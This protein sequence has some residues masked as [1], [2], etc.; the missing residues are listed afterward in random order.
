MKHLFEYLLSLRQLNYEPTRH[1]K[2][3]EKAW[4][5]DELE[6]SEGFYLGGTGL[7]S[8]AVL[9]VH[10]QQFNE[11]HPAVDQ[12]LG[13]LFQLLDFSFWK[14]NQKALTIEE[15]HVL[16]R[17]K[18]M[19]LNEKCTDSHE[20]V[21]LDVWDQFLLG[22][23]L[24]SI[25]VK[26][27]NKQ[28]IEVSP[29]V[30]QVLM[31]YETWLEQFDRFVDVRKRK[32]QI[33]RF[34]DYLFQLK[35]A[36][37]TED[38][39]IEIVLGTG[40]LKYFAKHDIY[41]PLFLTKLDLEF[42]A[43]KGLAKLVPSTKGS[44]LELEMLTGLEL[45]NHDQIITMYQETKGQFINPFKKAE[46]IGLLSE[47][48]HYLHPNGI[49]KL[50]DEP[51][52]QPKDPIVIDR[53]MIFVRKKSD[54]LL[55]E[56]LKKTLDYL[57]DGGKISKTIQAIVD[58]EALQLDE[59]EIKEWE[60]I[61]DQLLFPLPANDEQK[62]IVRRLAQ[63]IAI[64]VQGPP[65]TGKSHT[66]VN[67]I[68]H[69][70]A[71]GKKVLI[72]SEKD[73]ALRVLMDKMPE[74]IAPFCVSFLGGSKDVLAQIESSIT[75]L[76]D[77]LANYDEVILEKD[78]KVLSRQ[79]DMIHRQMNLTK[80]N[81]V[82]FKELDAKGQVFKD[83][84]IQPIEMAKL[85][86]QKSE[87]FSWFKDKVEMDTEAPLTEDE[88]VTLWELKCQLPK[89][90]ADIVQT[91][92]P[93]MQKLL[94]PEEYKTLLDS[95]L[96]FMTRLETL[97]QFEGL[98]EFPKDEAYIDDVY[99]MLEILVQKLQKIQ[100]DYGNEILKQCLLNKERYEVFKRIYDKQ[101]DVLFGI[102]ER[103]LLLVN[104]HIVC[105]YLN[106][107]KFSQYVDL[108][109][110]KVH[111][112]K[113]FTPLL[114]K[115]HKELRQFYETTYING[116]LLTD[117]DDFKRLM[118]Y[119][120]KMDLL[121]QFKVLWNK[122][123]MQCGADEIEDMAVHHVFEYNQKVKYF[124]MVLECCHLISS[125]NVKISQQIPSYIGIEYETL[126][127]LD[128]L[129]KSIDVVR[130]KL[131]LAHWEQE[132]EAFLF[133]MKAMLCCE[134]MHEMSFALYDSFVEKDLDG[135]TSQLGQIQYLTKIKE[136][137]T[138]FYSHLHALKT[139]MPMF[140]NRILNQL[141]LQEYLPGS[142]QDILEYGKLMTFL[143]ALDEWDVVLLE[144]KLGLLE[145]ESLKV[146]KQ[147]IYK[148]TWKNQLQ[149]V[150]PEQDRALSVWMQK[151]ARI[152]KGTGKLSDKYRREAREEME[153][154]QSAIPVWIM[155]I[156]EAIENFKVNPDLFD[157]VIM[158][159]SSQSN[160]L[161]LPIFMRAKR[162][163]IVGD[164]QQI[165]PLTPGVSDAQIQ[166][167]LTRHLASIDNGNLYDLQTSL[168]DIANH[169]FSSKGK[170]M[171]KEHFRCVPEIIEFSNDLCY[172]HEMIPLK[173]P[174]QFEQLTPPVMAVYVENGSRDDRRVNLEEAKQ[175]VADIKAMVQDPSYINKTI[176]V[177]SLL[178][179]EQAKV[180]QKLLV[181]EIGEKE[182]I[183]RQIICGDA[184]S[185]QGDERDIMFLSLVI[186]PNKRYTALNKKMYT[187]RFN[188]AASRA[189]CQ[190]RLYHSVTVDELSKEDLRRKLLMY[191]Q[192][193]S[194]S[195]VVSK[196]CDSLLERDV[197]ET[198]TNYGYIVH[199][200]VGVGKYDIDLV[201]EGKRSR[202]AIGCYGEVFEGVEKI[203]QDLERQ[204]VLKRAGWTFMT[205]RGS[206][207]Y[208]DKYAALKPIFEKLEQLGIQ[209]VT[210]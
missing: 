100:P 77:G 58:I 86:S 21:E 53:H 106:H 55:I 107:P 10:Q 45:P 159:E 20:A 149:H 89:T 84:V 127:E 26:E 92:L 141:E 48:I 177:I 140:A 153:K 120:E 61:E 139:T 70:L 150:T 180:I 158:D 194:V 66:I 145:V 73:K 178:G 36:L 90:H 67:L 143:N 41:H 1:I 71:N 75:H 54:V 105:D 205:V 114:M 28:L 42:D 146:M 34:Y 98:Y 94:S 11:S 59:Q 38:E 189:K 136:Q 27:L 122:N 47:F 190:M 109:R 116:H 118:L 39:G 174:Q 123:M 72:T 64:T 121:N 18:V 198:L 4:Y 31:N 17:E 85:V 117:H 46:Y 128:A 76:S 95:R 63:H 33:Q 74:E 97:K 79:L 87:Q 168:Y 207:F 2:S 160:I 151:M 191:C 154:C 131:K 29:H 163:V 167:L 111:G 133:K 50:V 108:I 193:P 15:L 81:I 148:L 169:V 175:I 24:P 14:D 183:K 209:P 8:S 126:Y 204:R 173:L 99:L 119:K 171:L 80:H 147:L 60:G 172:R 138:V 65:G 96:H 69:L 112:K 51:H 142:M 22:T 44:Y 129:F 135:V 23:S 12:V 91:D 203:E 179:S 176:G 103:E 155:P 88:F 13:T 101:K 195:T 49:V 130:T 210:Y 164:E 201:I 125:L 184:Y 200:N 32:R 181:Q 186:A 16:F 115:F 161:S 137:Y 30:E 157:V 206:L 6:E 202:L 166:E 156:K 110:D 197:Y 185:F 199:S 165:S 208:R 102:N 83:K 187:Q 62:D 56:D 7:D 52:L 182:I 19:S 68:S 170:L 113:A 35:Q 104:D 188:V 93:S 40:L 82:R 132:Y 152:G 144:E 37:L 5:L 124:E 78:I 192:K 9:E 57:D 3:Y 196:E 43:E 134:N 25:Q 162:A